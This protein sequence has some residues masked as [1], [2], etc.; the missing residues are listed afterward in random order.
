MAPALFDKGR[1]WNC[2][3][4]WWRELILL[5]EP[6]KGCGQIPW[7]FSDGYKPFKRCKL[8]LLESCVQRGL[9][10]WTSCQPPGLRNRLEDFDRGSVIFTDETSI[11][12]DCE[13][14][15]HIY[16]EP[17]TRFSLSC[18]SWITRAGVG[19]LER[20]HGRF[21]APQYLH[22][23][24]NLMLRSA[25]DRNLEGNFILQQYNHP[26]RCSMGV[27]SWFERRPKMEHM[28]SQVTWFER[29]RAYVG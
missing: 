2:S 11:S 17:G 19:V 18:W 26:V 12:S 10:R 22:I 24:E 28:A 23:F 16:R 14:R 4:S 7:Q 9:N 13:S 25:R 15:G 6:D 5:C 1:E 3:L 27:Q 29:C 20:I 8:S 21:N